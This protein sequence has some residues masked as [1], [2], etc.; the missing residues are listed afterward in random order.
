MAVEGQASNSRPDLSIRDQMF[1]ITDSVVVV[2]ERPDAH[3]VG[4]RSIEREPQ[5]L[6]QVPLLIR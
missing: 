3:P 2:V 5:A 1:G 6:H 4:R